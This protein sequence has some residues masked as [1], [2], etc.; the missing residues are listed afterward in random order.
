MFALLVSSAFADPLVAVVVVDQEAR[1]E[2]YALE[3][4]DLVV[5]DALP[6]DVAA[7]ESVRIVDPDGG[8]HPLDVAPGEAWVVSG[9]RGEA[10][11]SRLG[12]EVRTDVLLVRGEEAAVRGMAAALHAEVRP[13]EDGY[14]LTRRDILF[15]APW[16]EADG[17]SR[18]DEVAFV[19]VDAEEPPA[20]A[21][22][23]APA[24][25]A[26]PA[27]SALAVT[28]PTA[29]AAVPSPAS[30]APTS[31]APTAAPVEA[32]VAVA[33]APPAPVERK[34]PVL[35]PDPYIGSYLCG[36]GSPL[37][38]GWTGSFAAPSGSG[39]WY[40]SAPGVVRLVARNGAV[41]RAA[42]EIDRHY[43]RAVWSPEG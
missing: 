2:G 22:P 34:L 31:S 27:A 16:V 13:S 20:V 15:D 29:A 4:E 23:V 17:L 12:D 9:P 26:L 25:A 43:C 19:R 32:A 40:V 21:R 3:L 33:E 10:W 7:G 37:V 36:D 38:L 18:L 39:D 5:E 8:R 11:M 14:W 24:A 1:D 35:D 30:S 42:I 6:V 41:E 28:R